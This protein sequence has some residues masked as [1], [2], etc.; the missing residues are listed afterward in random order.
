MDTFREYDVARD[1]SET[2]GKGPDNTEARLELLKR[3]QIAATT[4]ADLEQDVRGTYF[5]L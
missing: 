5:I 1:A 2:V 3:D 4:V